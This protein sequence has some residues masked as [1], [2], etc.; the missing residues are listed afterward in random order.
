V[1]EL[2]TGCPALQ[3]G[4]RITT[5]R[6]IPRPTSAITPQLRVKAIAPGGVI[7]NPDTAQIGP[8]GKSSVT[9]ALGF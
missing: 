5:S 3:H 7:D 6:A 1:N 2:G 9:L 8:S 4:F